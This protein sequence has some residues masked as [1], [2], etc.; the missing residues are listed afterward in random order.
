LGLALLLVIDGIK[1]APLPTWRPIVVVATAAALLFVLGL[2]AMGWRPSTIQVTEVTGRGDVG[3]LK[4]WH[5][6]AAEALTSIARFAPGLGFYF[7]LADAL[8]L[9]VLG[10]SQ[11]RGVLKARRSAGAPAVDYSRPDTSD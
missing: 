9:L 11:L 5:D 8:A 1:V 4:D 2:N 3:A 10:L 6:L 7:A